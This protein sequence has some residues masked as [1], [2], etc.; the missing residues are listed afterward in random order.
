MNSSATEQNRKINGDQGDCRLGLEPAEEAH[1][2]AA[3][4]H[5]TTL[6]IHDANFSD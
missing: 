6:K 5:I 3:G 2:L 4:Q 1:M